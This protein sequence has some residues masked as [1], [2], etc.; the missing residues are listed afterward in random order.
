[1]RLQVAGS[2]TPLCQRAGR[3]PPHGIYFLTAL[4]TWYL[5]A[6]TKAPPRRAACQTFD[7]LKKSGAGEAIRTLDPN[8]GKVEDCNPSSSAAFNRRAAMSSVRNGGGLDLIAKTVSKT[9]SEWIFE[10]VKCA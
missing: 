1:G 10:T 4:P 5:A 7:F 2:T 9:V 6:K 8:S 3:Y